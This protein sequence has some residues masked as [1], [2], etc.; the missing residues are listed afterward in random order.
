MKTTNTLLF[1][2]LST[3]LLAITP[4]K[5]NFL[6]RTKEKLQKAKEISK[7][8][9]IQLSDVAKDTYENTKGDLQDKLNNLEV[10]DSKIRITE[11][12]PN[13]AQYAFY[14]ITHNSITEQISPF[15][16]KD[17]Q[18]DF[19]LGLRKGSGDYKIQLLATAGE[20]SSNSYYPIKTINVTNNDIEDRQYLLPSLKVQS[21]DINIINL[22]NEIIANSAND[23]EKAQAIY[24]WISKNI[25]YD[26]DVYQ[27]WLKQDPSALY[28]DNEDALNVLEV[29][30]TTCNGYTNLYAALA[31]AVGLKTQ[32]IW[33]LGN[34]AKHAWNKV[35]IDDSWE[36]VDT[37]WGAAYSKT[38][39]PEIYLFTPENIFSKDHRNPVV[40]ED[41]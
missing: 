39:T 27:R 21:T 35:L 34:N 10:T 25:A 7:E 33:G 13:G 16:I 22:A 24:H 9:L 20:R 2:L 31:R 28:G 26:N 41:K 5:A 38:P 1:I 32:I 4:A 30:K 6:E 8:K 14:L 3:Q 36:N 18:I 23:R 19:D 17:A 11:S 15:V 37:T 12:V 29:R 40:Q